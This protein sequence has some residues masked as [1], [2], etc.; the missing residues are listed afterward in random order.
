MEDVS[1]TDDT[2]PY[3]EIARS[4]SFRSLLEGKKRFLL[5]ITLFFLVFYFLLPVLTSYTTIL[6]HPAL[7]AITWAWVYGF[8]QFLMTWTLCAVYTKQAARFDTEVRAI[9]SENRK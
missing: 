2:T 5:P 6:N 7:G 9:I 1:M 4:A 3:S 8:A